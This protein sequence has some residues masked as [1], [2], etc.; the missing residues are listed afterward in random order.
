MNILNQIFDKIYIISSYSTQNRINN[1]IE[2]LNKKNIHYELVISPKKKYFG[3][4]NNEGLW[5]GQG[6]FSLL[7]ANESIFLKEFYIKSE[8]F[9]ILEDDIFFV[10]DYDKKIKLLMERLPDD[11]QILN[12]GYHTNTLLYSKIDNDEVYYK[13]KIGESVIG[14]HFVSYKNDVVKYILDKID[15]NV[16]PMDWFLNKTIYCNFN[17]YIC[18]DKIFYASSFRNYESDKD[19]FYKKYPSQIC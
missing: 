10:E 2:Y 15:I 5:L 1:I 19:M 12:L 7:S 4:N 13:L 16:Y 8:S 14:T 6:A 11:W 9:C 17:T 3:D 18:S